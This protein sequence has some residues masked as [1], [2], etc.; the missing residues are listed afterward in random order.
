MLVR[1]VTFADG[2]RRWRAAGRRLERQAQSSRW[3]TSIHRWTARD[4]DITLPEFRSDNPALNP[5]NSRGYGYWLW[6]PYILRREMQL[7]GPGESLLFLDAGCQVNINPTSYRRLQDYLAD[8]EEHGNLVME[9]DAP[10]TRWCKR[11]LVDSFFGSSDLAG[12]HLVEPG[13]LFMRKNTTNLHLLNSWIE[14]G[15][16]EDHHYLNDSPS[17]SENYQEF[18]EHRHDQSLLS[19]LRRTGNLYAIPQETYFP[20]SWRAEG[21][22]YPIWAVRNSLPVS[23]Y[24]S[25]FSSKAVTWVRDNKSPN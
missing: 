4:L 13:V 17:R 23:L 14:W 16:L 1:L 24:G 7:L 25:S 5:E 2:S 10:I 11:D 18:I 20:D 19:C 8:V 3:F 6:R 9:I 22:N 21:L 15:R 12:I